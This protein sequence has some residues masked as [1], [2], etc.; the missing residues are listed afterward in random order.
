MMTAL[1][2]QVGGDHYAN[3]GEHQPW[4]VLPNWLTPA[5]L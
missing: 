4:K 2:K 5:E 1:D 3:F